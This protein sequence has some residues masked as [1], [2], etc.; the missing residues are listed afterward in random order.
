MMRKIIKNNNIKKRILYNAKFKEMYMLKG[1]T[2]LKKYGCK[3]VFI[4]QDNLHFSQKKRRKVEK[5]N[6]ININKIRNL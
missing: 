4:F 6:K 5:S 1:K 3:F 2:N